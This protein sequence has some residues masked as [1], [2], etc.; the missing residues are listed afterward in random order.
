MKWILLKIK[1]KFCRH[2]YEFHH[3]VYGMIGNTDI[4]IK[5]CTECGKTIYGGEY[6]LPDVLHNTCYF[7][8]KEKENV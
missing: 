7:D 3:W 1:Q 8:N 5:K 2:N 4:M 6:F